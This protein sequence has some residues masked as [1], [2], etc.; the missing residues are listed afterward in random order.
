MARRTLRAPPDLALEAAAAA[1]G[2]RRVAG[3][4]E[5]GRG[6]LAGPV[7]AAAVIFDPARVPEGL[8][9]SKRL[10]PARREALARA[11]AAEAQVSV[12]LASVEEIDSLG[13]WGATALAMVRALAPLDPDLALIDGLHLPPGLTCPARAMV[14]GDGRSASIAAASIMAKVSRD[15]L[16]AALAQHEPRYGWATNMGYPTAAH[17]AALRQHG[18]TQHH[19]RSFAPIRQML[20]PDDETG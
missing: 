4:D 10:S 6:P 7:V 12:A 5:A 19:R 15:R 9:D 16:M 14:G 17:H 13:I 3:V 18:P 11:L 2:A 1:S 20:C 8:D